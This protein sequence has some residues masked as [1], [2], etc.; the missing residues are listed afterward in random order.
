MNS[1]CEADSQIPE[2]FKMFEELLYVPCE[3][4]Q[5]LIGITFLQYLIVITFLQYLSN[6]LLLLCNILA[7]FDCYFFAAPTSCLSTSTKPTLHKC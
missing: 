2:L 5:N 1:Q 7:I 3:F 4:E 6:I